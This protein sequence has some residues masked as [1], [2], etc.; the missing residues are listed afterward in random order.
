MTDSTSRMT[1]WA[2]VLT[3]LAA[4]ADRRPD[5]PEPKYISVSRH[6]AS[7]HV[8]PAGLAG[9]GRMPGHVRAYGTA[10][11][12]GACVAQVVVS[13]HLDGVGLVTVLCTSWCGL[14][15]AAHDHDVC[16][17]DLRDQVGGAA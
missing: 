6:G 7:I 16:I 3:A 11:S 10:D 4:L 15:A 1:G 17:A 8:D 13:G 12:Q 2:D 9:W 5:L 14:P